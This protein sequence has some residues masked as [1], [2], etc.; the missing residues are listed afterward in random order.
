MH[1]LCLCVFP[2][3][4]SSLGT[5]QPTW[6][7]SATLLLTFLVPAATALSSYERPAFTFTF[8]SKRCQ[9][10]GPSASGRARDYRRAERMEGGTRALSLML[11][12]RAL[13]PAYRHLPS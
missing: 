3:L 2:L 9:P 11:A 1:L 7:P 10:R 8:L 12:L 5:P 13:N 4:P 6:T